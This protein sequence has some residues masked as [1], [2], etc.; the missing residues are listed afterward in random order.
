[1]DLTANLNREISASGLI[2][3]VAS[4]SCLHTSCSLTINE[5]ADPWVLL[6]LAA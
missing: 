4:H 6:Y 5:N 3:G 1:M 2:C